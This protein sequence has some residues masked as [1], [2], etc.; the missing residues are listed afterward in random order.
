LRKKAIIVKLGQIGDVIMAIPAARALYE[1]GYEVDWVVGRAARPLLECYSWVRV[2]PADDKAIFTGSLF[3]RVN[4]I[5]RFWSAVVSSRYDICATL[6]YDS[7]FRILTL[8]IRARRKFSLSRRSNRTRELLLGRSY[9]DEFVRILRGE[10]DS[11]GEQSTPP[12][13][14]NVLPPSPLPP[15][16]A[17]RRVAIVPGGAANLVSRQVLRRWPIERYVAL[18][19]ELVVRDWEVVLLG[20]PEDS[21][22]RQYFARLTM[23]DCLGK[24]SL[25][26][27]IAVC[28]SCDAVVSH[29][30]GPL[31]LAGL[32]KS[33]LVGIFGPSDPAMFLPRRSFVAGL[34]GGA[35]L[36]CRP[37]YDGTNFAPCGFNACVHEVTV[38]MVLAELDRLLSARTAGVSSPWRI[39]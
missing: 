11:C 35:G 7:R 2:I 12:L 1:Q 17:S 30:T 38:D 27:V 20:G 26:E 22:L 13:R 3:A 33:C 36:A 31:H 16:S 29:D 4:A 21:E 34:W 14:P 25:P 18:A 39:V 6:Y 28:D 19:S 5:F 24:L 8:P 32:S 10:Q 37:C 15:K 9:M 23:T